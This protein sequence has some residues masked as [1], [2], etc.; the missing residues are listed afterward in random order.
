MTFLIGTILLL[1][2]ALMAWTCLRQ[3]ADPAPDPAVRPADPTRTRVWILLVAGFALALFRPDEEMTAGEDP[4]AYFN[5]ALSFAQ[6]QRIAY[7]DPALAELD[8]ADRVLFRYGHAAFLI[9][10]DAV[11]WAEDERMERTQPWFFPAYALTMSVPAA[12]GLP[13]ATFLF[14]PL[15]AIGVGLLLARLAR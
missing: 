4:G 1:F 8:P 6:H 11:L 2:M 9:T 15:L 7:A 13:Y 3:P 5:S 12:L 10:K 14:A